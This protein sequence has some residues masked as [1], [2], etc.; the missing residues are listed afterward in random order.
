MKTWTTSGG[1]TIQRILSGRCNCYLIRGG[2][3][4]LL[5]DCGGKRQW[6]NLSTRLSRFGV[7]TDTPLTLVLT[8][9]H[10]DHAENAATLKREFGAVILVHESEADNLKRGKNPDIRGA[11]P[12]FR[13][14]VRTGERSGI[15]TR[16]GYAGTQADLLVG[17]HHD[18]QPQGFPAAV[19][20]TPGHTPGSISVIVDNE[21]ALVG[22]TLFGVFPGSVF[23]PFAVD[24]E[25]LA[26]SWKKLLDTNCTL[27][28]PGHGRPR[29]RGR[30]QRE[31][32]QLNRGVK[33]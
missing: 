30:L 15:M 2:N 14:L 27:F 12:F 32:Q 8:H 7:G 4:F 28:L 22:D 16:M 21:I 10:F 18:L 23:P 31:Y 26:R 5:V 19:I 11:M 3:G 33:V 20:H 6:N 25:E 9:S 17:D 24:P 1:V 29:T 13:F